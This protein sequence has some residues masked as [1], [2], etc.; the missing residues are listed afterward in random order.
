MAKPTSVCSCNA[1]VTF[2]WRECVTPV[3]VS[4]AVEHLMHLVAQRPG[5]TTNEYIDADNEDAFE[6]LLTRATQGRLK[7]IDHVKTIASVPA[8]D[9]FEI[10]WTTIK[11]IARNPVS[12]LIEGDLT[13]HVR[14]YYVEEGEPWIVGLYAHEKEIV[15]GDDDETRRRQNEHIQAAE[16]YALA[17]AHRRW[18]VEAL[19]AT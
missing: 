2:C 6:R 10:R 18:G 12:G 15:D 14:L 11:A 17:N 19:S 7:P 16:A 13:L 9:M 8:M 1:P 4:A 5:R 3:H